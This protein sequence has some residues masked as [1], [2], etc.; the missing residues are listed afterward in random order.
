MDESG[1]PTIV[2][3]LVGAVIAIGVL[4]GLTIVTWVLILSNTPAA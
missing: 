2:A 3:V 1:I 4:A